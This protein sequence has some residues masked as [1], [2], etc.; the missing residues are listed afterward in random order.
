MRQSAVSAVRDQLSPTH[1]LAVR[2]LDS[3]D[4]GCTGALQRLATLECAAA[5]CY[6]MDCARRSGVTGHE[7]CPELV[8]DAV[9]AV[10]WCRTDGPASAQAARAI[11]A[12]YIRWASVHFGVQSAFVLAMEKAMQG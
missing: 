12:R 8:A 6:S 9:S 3:P 4:T 11:S 10:V 2:L 5:G 7:P 1:Y